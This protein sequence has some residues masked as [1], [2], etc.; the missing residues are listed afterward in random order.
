[1]ARVNTNMAS[2]DFSRLLLSVCL[3]LFQYVRETSRG[4][5]INFHPISPPYLHLTVRVIFGLQLV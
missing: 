5:V 2:A 1:M 4:K 3:T